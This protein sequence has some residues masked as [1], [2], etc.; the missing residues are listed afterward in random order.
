VSHI[1]SPS[2]DVHLVALIDITT[3][4]DLPYVFVRVAGT[5]GCTLGAA[6]LLP[7]T[8]R[9]IMGAGA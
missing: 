7:D 2:F 3:R 8:L 5:D 1:G 4:D 6:K 9:Q